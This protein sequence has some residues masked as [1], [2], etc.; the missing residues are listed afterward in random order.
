MNHK[1]SFSSLTSLKISDQL[2]DQFRPFQKIWFGLMNLMNILNLN[3]LFWWIVY[4]INSNFGALS[5]CPFRINWPDTKWQDFCT[6][7]IDPIVFL[8]C[9]EFYSTSEFKFWHS[10][11][12]RIWKSSEFLDT[13]PVDQNSKE[14]CGHLIVWLEYWKNLVVR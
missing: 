4:L 6:S 1:S 13:K 9:Q 7:K 12:W 3:Y 5:T 11:S 14:F 2:Q 8:P 10:K